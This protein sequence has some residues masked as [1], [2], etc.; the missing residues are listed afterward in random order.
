[1]FVTLKIHAYDMIYLQQ[2]HRHFTRVLF[3]RKFAFAKFCDKKKPLRKYPTLQWYAVSIH[4]SKWML[5]VPECGHHRA[6]DCRYLI[7]R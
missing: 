4:V 6:N 2:R 3:S 7:I 5:R 1:M